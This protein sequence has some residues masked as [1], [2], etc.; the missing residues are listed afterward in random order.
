[1][2][3]LQPIKTEWTYK[4][5][6]GF[7]EQAVPLITVTITIVIAWKIVVFLWKRRKDKK[8]EDKR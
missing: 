2:I 7:C 1:M 8:N 6:W 4:W 3:E 5:E